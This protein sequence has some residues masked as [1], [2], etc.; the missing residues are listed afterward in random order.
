MLEQNSSESKCALCGE[1]MPAGEEMFNYHGYS[2]PC[3]KPPLPPSK[4]DLGNT[5]DGYHTFNELYEHR[6]ALFAVVCYNN[7]GWKAKL[8]SDGTMFE[9]WFIAGI[10]TPAGTLTYH[11]PDRWWNTMNCRVL[12]RAPEWDGATPD[13]SIGRLISLLGTCRPGT[14]SGG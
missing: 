1:P 11:L 14:V 4:P 6:H 13:E 7:N 2:G 3:P 8:H 12:E 5:S 10:W 9:G